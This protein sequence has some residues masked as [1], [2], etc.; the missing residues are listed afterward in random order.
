MGH[1]RS[2]WK[3]CLNLC[4]QIYGE[5][6]NQESSSQLHY[7]FSHSYSKV[8]PSLAEEYHSHSGTFLQFAE[9]DV[10]NRARVKCVTASEG[11]IYNLLSI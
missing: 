10:E 8:F 3:T 7:D 4:S 6:K 5:I 2:I 1:G 9:F 11:N